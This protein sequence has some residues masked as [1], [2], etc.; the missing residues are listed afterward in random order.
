MCVHKSSM[1]TTIRSCLL[2]L[3]FIA[4]TTSLS[5]MRVLITPFAMAVFIWLVIDAFA[6]WM[7]GLSSKIPYGAA[8]TVAIL[9]VVA[10]LTGVV[11][12]V[13]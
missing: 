9:T 13:T 10:V 7:N 1:D 3:T 5:L 8:L 6:R 2:I 12:I 4:G 11:L